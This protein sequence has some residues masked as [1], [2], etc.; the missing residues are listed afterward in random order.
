MSV[1]LPLTIYSPSDV[2][3]PDSCIKCHLKQTNKQKL[4]MCE[5]KLAYKFQ[6][7]S[8]LRRRLL[9]NQFHIHMLGGPA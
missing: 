1:T 6:T 3:T 4:E 8:N 7:W 2:I 9:K 5:K